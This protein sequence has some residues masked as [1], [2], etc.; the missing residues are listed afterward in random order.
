MGTDGFVTEW[1]VDVN[2]ENKEWACR[3]W[4]QNNAKYNSVIYEKSSK[5]ILV[6]GVENNKSVIR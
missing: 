6:A 2:P 4:S 1:K 5:S 3:K